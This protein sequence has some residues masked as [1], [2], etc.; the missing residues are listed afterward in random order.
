[1]REY[2]TRLRLRMERR[3]FRKVLEYAYAQQVSTK[4]HELANVNCPG[5]QIDHPSQRRHECLYLDSLQRLH[6]YFD[7][8]ISLLD[9]EKAIETVDALVAPLNLPMS[10]EDVKTRIGTLQ[11]R[12]ASVLKKTEDLLQNQ[13]ESYDCC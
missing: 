2:L 13:D 4:I 5:C 8:A 1:M 6:L 12:N 3:F 10:Y 7:Q 9:K 11:V